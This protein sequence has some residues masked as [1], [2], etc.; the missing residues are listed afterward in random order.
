MASPAGRAARLRRCRLAVWVS[1][2]RSPAARANS[3][4]LAA[5]GY[6]GEAACSPLV[7]SS[8][9][10]NALTEAFGGTSESAPFVAGAAADVIEAYSNTHNGERPTPAMVKEI[11]DGSATDIDAPGGEQGAGQVN[12]YQAVLAAE[13]MPN[14]TATGASPAPGLLST[15]TQL[16]VNGDGGTKVSTSL[17]VY[18][19]STK[20]TTVTAQL[21]KLGPA[22]Q[23][24]PT[25]TENVSAP[26]PS[27]PVPAAG[28]PGCR[29]DHVQRAGGSR[30]PQRQHDLADP[31]NSNIL[32]YILT[33]P[34]GG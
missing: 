11:I 19:A 18:N 4:D 29:P 8:C 27:L 25:V 34:E 21:R 1:R 20:A 31:T 22:T 28:R 5:P 12:I 6:G 2:S 24:A 26:D 3:P 15:P 10:T 23:L 7:T 9:P 16:D 17:S 14:S 33:D 13:Q 32:Y 30:S